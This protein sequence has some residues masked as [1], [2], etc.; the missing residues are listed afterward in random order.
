MTRQFPELE[1]ML[2]G[3]LGQDWPLDY[4]TWQGAIAAYKKEAGPN[5]VRQA[6][7]ELDALLAHHPDEGEL[8]RIGVA[9]GCD[10]EPSADGSGYRE[11]LQAV[12]GSLAS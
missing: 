12:R 2:G 8:Q 10:Y 11:W 4:D 7:S 9:L 6:M 5:A 1:Q 3:Y